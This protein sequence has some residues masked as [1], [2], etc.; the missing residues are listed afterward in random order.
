MNSK[1]AFRKSFEGPDP[2]TADARGNQSAF[3]AS[4]LE[5]EN[6]IIPKKS[7]PKHRPSLDGTAQLL[8]PMEEDWVCVPVVSLFLSFC[9]LPFFSLLPVRCRGVRLVPSEGSGSL[10]ASSSCGSTIYLGNCTSIHGTISYYQL[11]SNL[12]PAAAAPPLARSSR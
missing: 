2:T 3:V 7:Y 9:Y 1:K 11:P 4:L 6:G 5:S 12:K 10:I 8:N